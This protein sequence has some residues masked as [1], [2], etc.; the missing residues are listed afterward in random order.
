MDSIGML[1]RKIFLRAPSFFTLCLISLPGMASDR[2]ERGGAPSLQIVS[3]FYNPGVE[4]A[5]LFHN[6]LIF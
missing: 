1:E 4:T 3:N 2:R 6:C 5:G